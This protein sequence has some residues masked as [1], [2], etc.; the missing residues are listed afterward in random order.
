MVAPGAM[1][2]LKGFSGLLRGLMKSAHRTTTMPPAVLPERSAGLPKQDRDL[3][4]VA[5]EQVALG[6]VDDVRAEVLAHDAVP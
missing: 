1:L 4:A 3:V 5:A 2:L 6:L